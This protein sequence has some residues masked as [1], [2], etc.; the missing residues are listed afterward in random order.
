MKIRK[1]AVGALSKARNITTKE[2]KVLEDRVWNLGKT[3]HQRVIRLLLKHKT[4]KLKDILKLINKDICVVKTNLNNFDSL[5]EEGEVKCGRCGSRK[6]ARVELQTR[7]SDESATI[8]YRC[9]NCKC[10]WKK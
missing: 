6:V 1:K 3:S 4:L 7:S 5:I 8:F 10:R 9:V 2:A